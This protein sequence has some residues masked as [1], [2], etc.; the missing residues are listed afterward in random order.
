MILIACP[1]LVEQSNTSYLP[2]KRKKLQLTL[3]KGKR[4]VPSSEAP[5]QAEESCD[6]VDF[7]RCP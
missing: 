4:E 5:L 1:T 2:Q 6:F 7:S 3:T